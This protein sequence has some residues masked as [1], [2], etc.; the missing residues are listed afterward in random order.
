MPTIHELN[1]QSIVPFI[2]QSRSVPRH[3]TEGGPTSSLKQT[4]VGN[5]VEAAHFSVASLESPFAAALLGL[6]AQHNFRT[7]Y[8]ADQNL[9]TVVNPHAL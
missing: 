1:R 9:L 7:E 8:C 5:V 3:E 2:T 6:A 4:D